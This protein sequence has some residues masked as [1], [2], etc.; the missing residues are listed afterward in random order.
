MRYAIYGIN[1]VT[2]DFLYVFDNFDVTYFIEDIVT[3]KEFCGKPV[4]CTSQIEKN[5]YELFDKIIICEFDKKQKEAVL[6]SIGYE[7][8]KDYIFEQDLFYLL[9]N[10]QCCNVEEKPIVV[11]G[12]GKRAENFVNCFKKLNIEFFVDSY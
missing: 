12:T 6:I 5:M 1:R 11:W 9:D 7:Y 8:E 4:I 2:K 3:E 10:D